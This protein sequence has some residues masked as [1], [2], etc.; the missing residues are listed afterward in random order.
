VRSRFG[1]ALLGAVAG[2]VLAAF[3]AYALTH[4]FSPNRHDRELEALMTAF[5]V[6][7]PLGTVVGTVVGAL[8]RRRSAG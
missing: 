2:Y 6:A 5:F 1:G 3:A 7:G 8:R 4:A